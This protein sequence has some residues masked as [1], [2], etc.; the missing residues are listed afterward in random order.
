[1]LKINQAIDTNKGN[2]YNIDFKRHKVTV[3][4]IGNWTP[5]LF[6]SV[7]EE[8]VLYHFETK[9]ANDEVID[10]NDNIDLQ[11]PKP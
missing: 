5:E 9:A 7:A 3:P 6:K 2:K 1:M 11:S 10:I 4:H 8:K